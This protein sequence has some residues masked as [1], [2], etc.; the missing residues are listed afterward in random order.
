M[1]SALNPAPPEL[2]GGTMGDRPTQN[3]SSNAEER[4][5]SPTNPS[6]TAAHPN[7]PSANRMCSPAI[8]NCIRAFSMFRSDDR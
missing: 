2:G 7:V 4:D 8:V 5:R 3:P 1:K 6:L